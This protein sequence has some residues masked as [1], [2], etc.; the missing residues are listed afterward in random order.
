MSGPTRPSTSASAA[1]KSASV[2]KSALAVSADDTD[3]VISKN[4]IIAASIVGG[5]VSNSILIFVVG[6]SFY[7]GRKYK[8]EKENSKAIAT[9]GHNHNENKGNIYISADLSPLR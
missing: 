6:L 5:I 3:G 4:A 1:A 2:A 7:L 9:P 8:N